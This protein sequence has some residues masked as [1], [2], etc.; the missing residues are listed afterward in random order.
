MNRCKEVPS[1][2]EDRSKMSRISHY[3]LTRIIGQGGFGQVY[4]G[5]DLTTGLT[6]ALKVVKIDNEKT[7]QEINNEIEIMEMVRHC[8][9][10]VKI[11]D[12]GD[13]SSATANYI[14][15]QLYNGGSLSDYIDKNARTL[16]Y[17]SAAYKE[18][19]LKLF[20]Q[21]SEALECVHASDYVHSDIKSDNVFIEKIGTRPVDVTFH[22][23]DFG[24]SENIHDPVDREGKIAG[25]VSHLPPEKRVSKE[26]DIWSFGVM[27]YKIMYDELPFSGGSNAALM[28]NI[29]HREPDFRDHPL[30]SIVQRMLSKLP[31]RRPTASQLVVECNRLRGAVRERDLGEASVSNIPAFGRSGSAIIIPSGWGQSKSIKPRK[32]ESTEEDEETPRRRQAFSI[33]RKGGEGRMSEGRG[34]RRDDSEERSGEISRRKSFAKDTDRRFLGFEE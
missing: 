16:P 21:I 24:I 31:S 20:C 33:V 23:G 4:L 19:T 9:Y 18:F 12:H 2:C 15:M 32:D 27:M 34:K 28:S 30:K 17:D 5:K 8:P 11:I 25:T 1:Y 3:E 22:L 7:R 26:R 6:I 13:V 14:V 10:V 29:E